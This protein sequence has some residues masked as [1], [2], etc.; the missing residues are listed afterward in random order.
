[1]LELYKQWPFSILSVETGSSPDAI[2]QIKSSAAL[3][4]RSWWDSPSKTG[5]GP[6][7]NAW[8]VGGYPAVYVLDGNGVIRF[9]DIRYE[10]LLKGVRQLLS[11]APEPLATAR[12]SE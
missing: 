3:P 12:R 5:P 6:I 8:N 11:Q 2:K 7:A 4:Y 1:M 9:V 10:D